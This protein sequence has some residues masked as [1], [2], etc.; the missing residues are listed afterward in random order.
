MPSDGLDDPVADA[1]EAPLRRQPEDVGARAVAP[2]HVGAALQE[3]LDR[4]LVLVHDG[5]EE[6][7]VRSVAERGS[8]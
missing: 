5:E 8:T 3:A 6:K 7:A 4:G 1:D 2:P